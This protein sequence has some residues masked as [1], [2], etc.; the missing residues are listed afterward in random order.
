MR[1]AV[2][3]LRSISNLIIYHQIQELVNFLVRNHSDEERTSFIRPFSEALK[4]EEGNKSLSEDDDRKREIF[5][6]L[7]PEVKT[8]GEGTE[9]GTSNFP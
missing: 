8:L 4:T 6:H 7:V 2:R 1:G 5:S 9:K 3:D